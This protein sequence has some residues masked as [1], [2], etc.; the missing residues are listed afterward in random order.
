MGKTTI[1]WTD[2]TWNPVR[3]CSRI[4]PGCEHCYAERIATRFSGPGK[5]FEGLI[6]LVGKAKRHPDTGYVAGGGRGIWN[7]TVRLVPEHLADPIRWRQPRRVFVNSMSDLFHENLPDDHIAAVFGVMAMAPKHTFQVLTKRGERMREWFKYIE[8]A[9][10]RS[11]CL[12]E[13]AEWLY[14]HDQP[15][16]HVAE[17]IADAADALGADWPLRNVW[18]GTSVENQDYTDRIGYLLETPAAVR[19]LSCEPLLGPLD[20]EEFFDPA[21]APCGETNETIDWVIAGC[22]S[23]P[24]RRTCDVA[25]LRSLRDQCARADVPFFLKQA[26]VDLAESLDVQDPDKGDDVTPVVGAGEGSYRK[27]S[28]AIIELPYLDGEQHAEFPR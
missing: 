6:K 25:W 26:Q 12:R 13:A 7:G 11:V 2:D 17:R 15:G 9:G 22:E 28:G 19:F 4:S 16:G 24:G 18:L 14:Q 3:G 27:G 10:G 20:V 1:S 21:S 8:D 23:G 5:P